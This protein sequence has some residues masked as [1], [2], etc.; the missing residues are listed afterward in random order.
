MR[1]DHSV[2]TVEAV[3]EGSGAVGY[4][5]CEGRRGGGGGEEKRDVLTALADV[6]TALADVWAALPDVQTV[7]DDST[8]CSS[9]RAPP[10]G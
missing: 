1:V 7:P 5:W 10:C 3:E 2:G 4:L 6:L 9:G 8:L